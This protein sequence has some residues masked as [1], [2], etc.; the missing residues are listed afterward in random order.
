MS[1]GKKSSGLNQVIKKDCRGKTNYLLKNNVCLLI[2][3]RLV[4][5]LANGNLLVAAMQN[6]QSNLR[7]KSAK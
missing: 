6:Q 5:I 2:M 3:Q 4:V 1:R 7:K